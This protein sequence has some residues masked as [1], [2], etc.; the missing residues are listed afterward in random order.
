MILRNVRVTSMGLDNNRLDVLWEYSNQA[1]ALDYEVWVERAGALSGPFVPIGRTYNSVSFTDRSADSDITERYYYRLRVVKR[2]DLSTLELSG[3]VVYDDTPNL[4]V[5]E[6]Q[7]RQN[8]V[9]REYNGIPIL[10]YPVRTT[11]VRCP[12]CYDPEMGQKIRSQCQICY[13]TS[14]ITGYYT[15]MLMYIQ[16]HEDQTALVQNAETDEI[17]VRT[18]T[19]RITGDI[20]LQFGDLILEHTNERW[21]VS[22]WERTELQRARVSLNA[23]LHHV[24]ETDV[25]YRVPLPE[26]DIFDRFSV[27]KEYSRPYT[28][29]P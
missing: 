24:F 7:L 21:L 20:N 10:Y 25:R 9:Q 12:E 28:L 18:A 29:N 14:Y 3:V 4:L 16:L 26:S 11:G 5:R 22:A 27:S 19:A 17:P 23:R 15:P 13:D 2:S 1:D 8:L 6:M